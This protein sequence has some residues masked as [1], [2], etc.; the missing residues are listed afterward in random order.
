MGN[1]RFLAGSTAREVLGLL[2]RPCPL[3]VSEKFVFSPGSPPRSAH[4]VTPRPGHRCRLGA[5]M[6]VFNSFGPGWRRGGAAP[7]SAPLSAGCANMRLMA[8]NDGTQ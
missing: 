4:P 7:P 3:A 5:L 8:R 1:S 2:T 6:T